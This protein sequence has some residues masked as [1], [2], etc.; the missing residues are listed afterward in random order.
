[1]VLSMVTFMLLY[2]LIDMI[3]DKRHEIVELEFPVRVLIQYYAN[4]LP[5]ILL[6]VIP[7]AVLLSLLFVLGGFARSNEY[8]ALLSGGVS[9]YRVIRAPVSVAALVAVCVFLVNE[10]VIPPTAARA[11]EIERTKLLSDR[12]MDTESLTWVNRKQGSTCIVRTYDPNVQAGSDVL[13][14][15]KRDGSVVEKLEA[16]R[17]RWDSGTRHWYLED[18]YRIQIKNGTEP[19]EHFEV[20]EAPVFVTP[21]ILA[22]KQVPPEE[23]GMLDLHREITSMR[24]AGLGDPSRWV[25]FHAK[26]AMPATNFVIAFLAIPFA[27]RLKRHGLALSFGISV[28]VSMTYLFLFGLGV[29][30]GK[31]QHLPAWLSAWSAN[32]VFLAA[33]LT[34]MFKTEK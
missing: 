23:R 32:M 34:L 4:F 27:L 14:A 9:F 16:S 20:M 18:G 26:A 13:I 30:L 12:P 2:G 7:V 28:C 5:T 31:A 15:F 3:S 1:M 33:G 11:H 6:Q 21:E 17:M 8:T 24:D 22:A 19:R 25:D 29:G 10:F